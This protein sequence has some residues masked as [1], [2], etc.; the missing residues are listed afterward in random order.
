MGASTQRCQETHHLGLVGAV[1][2]P[3]G[4]WVR[5]SVNRMAAIDAHERQVFDTLLWGM[6][7]STIFVR[8]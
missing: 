2:P 5:V 6:V 1:G 8:C 4:G 3:P 7:T